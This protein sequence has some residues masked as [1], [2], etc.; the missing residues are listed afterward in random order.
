MPQIPDI[1]DFLSAWDAPPTP[2][3]RQAPA[4]SEANAISTLLVSI[5]W[6]GKPGTNL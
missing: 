2:D 3:D 1:E 6:N 4:I 5:T